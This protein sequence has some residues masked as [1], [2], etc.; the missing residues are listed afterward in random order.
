MKT[1]DTLPP[2]DPAE[3]QKWL[4]GLVRP[5]VGAVLR[6]TSKA[7]LI[8]QGHAGKI[9]LYHVGERALAFRRRDCLMLE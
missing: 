9:K 5:S 3:Y 2:T 6:G 1:E 7:T 4:D 8:R